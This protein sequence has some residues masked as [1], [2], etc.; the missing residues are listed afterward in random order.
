MWPVTKYD[1]KKQQH[2]AAFRSADNCGEMT[3]SW[4]DICDKQTLK[5]LFVFSPHCVG[6]SCSTHFVYPALSHNCNFFGV[7]LFGFFLLVFVSDAVA[8]QCYCS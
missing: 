7:A 4:I 1:H 5:Q 8:R 3:G 6:N 2:R